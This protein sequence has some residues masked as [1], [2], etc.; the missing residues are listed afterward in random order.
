MYNSSMNE[1]PS[2]LK[3]IL[4]TILGEG[5]YSYNSLFDIAK[6]IGRS[7]DI[8]KNM[9]SD[10]ANGDQWGG[11]KYW[12]GRQPKEESNFADI[13]RMIVEDDQIGPSLDRYRDSILGT[14]PEW[15]LLDKNDKVGTSRENWEEEDSALTEWWDNSEAHNAMKQALRAMLWGGKSYLRLYVPRDYSDE[16][17]L[18]PQTSSLK[19][20]MKMIYLNHI[21]CL[22][23]GSILDEYGRTKAMYYR[24]TVFVEQEKSEVNK[25][26]IHTREKVYILSSENNL[27][28]K[29]R[30]EQ[31][32]DSVFEDDGT[33]RGK[34][35]LIELSREDGVSIITRGILDKQD[36]LN[37]AWTNLGRNDDLAG[38]RTIITT[39]AQDVLNDSGEKVEWVL[40]AAQRVNLKGEINSTQFGEQYAKPEAIVI[41]PIDPQRASLPTITSLKESILSDFNQVWVSTSGLVISGESRKQSRRAFDKQIKK[42]SAVMDRALKWILS[43]VLEMAY[44]LTEGFDVT[45]L[46]DLH[47]RART[48]YDA[49]KG[50][51]EIY[52][53]LA[54]AYDKGNIDLETLLESNPSV[55]DVGATIQRMG[56]NSNIHL[57]L[58]I[59]SKGAVSKETLTIAG[60]KTEYHAPIIEKFGNLLPAGTTNP[61]DFSNSGKVPDGA[62]PK[63]EP[64]LPKDNQGDIKI[65]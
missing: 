17:N 40:G 45:R 32:Y 37:V 48:I 11:G 26:E 18:I 12:R 46:Q 39:N 62:N 63:K 7:K 15:T 2:S 19:D 25:M 9:L 55:D 36:R 38:F 41:D 47:I 20:S 23:G 4:S 59:I 64:N 65:A 60:I 34:F 58:D 28:D 30:V 22:N 54:I 24:Y 61:N 35:L 52:K 27:S 42:E 16:Y 14:D 50:D 21:D 31:E 49:P 53:E 57:L 33:K 51:L 13:E 29:Y 44:M 10:Y 3:T 5:Q 6:K 56:D 8:P 1:L 43:T